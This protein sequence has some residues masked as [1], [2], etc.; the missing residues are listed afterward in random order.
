MQQRE[1]FLQRNLAVNFLETQYD[2]VHELFTPW[3]VA[4]GIDG[5]T[6]FGLKTNIYVYQWDNLKSRVRKGYK[7]IN[8]FPT[9]VE[10]FTLTQEPEAGYP[11]KTVTFGFTDYEPV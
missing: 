4:I 9:N 8:A 10:G 11:E 7:F 1:S 2:I 6:N 5:L 3:A